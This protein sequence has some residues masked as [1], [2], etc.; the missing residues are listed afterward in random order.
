MKNLHFTNT[1]IQGGFWGHFTELNRNVT[2]HSVYDRF[3]ETGRFAALRCDWKPGQPNQ[4]H[5]FWDSDVAKWLES[6]A[7]LTHT[8]WDPALEALVDEA[9]ENICR[10]QKPSGYFNSYYLTVEPG[11]EFQVRDNHELYCAG[12]LMEAAIAYD[13]ATGKDALLR[14]MCRYADY[15]YQVFVV[16]QRAA[17]VTP[18]HE[19]IELALLK[20]ADYTGVEKYRQLAEFFLNQRGL[21][22]EP[23]GHPDMVILPEYDQSEFPIRELDEAKGHAVRAAYLYIA[24]AMLA[25]ER[26]DEQLAQVCQNLLTGIVEQKLSITGGVGS[27][28]HGENYGKPYALPNRTCYNETCAAI[29]LALF[30]K[31]MQA[32]Q[33]SSVYGDVIERILFNGFLSGLS[34]NGKAFFYENALEIDLRDYDLSL[35]SKPENNVQDL[36][37]GTLNPRRLERLEVFNCSCCP[38]NVT[39]ILASLP[40]FAY[41]VDEN[42]VYCHQFLSARTELTMGGKPAVLEQKTNYPA[43]GKLSFTWHGEPATLAVRIPDWCVEYTGETENG[44]ARFAVTD[45]QTVELELP[46]E[47]HF[48]EA[49]P[50]VRDLAGSCAVMRGPL[51]Y[52]LEG[53]DNGSLR[54]VE[55]VSGGAVT[56]EDAPEYHAPVLKLEALRRPKMR[57]LYQLRSLERETFTARLIPYFAF[58]NRG[59]S[60]MMVWL[61]VR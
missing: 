16:E 5:I 27:E 17:F 41:T 25:K 15:I 22:Y 7:Y 21:R 48:V 51:V 10:N 56:V 57:S 52:C 61:P 28:G 35:L 33:V 18:G 59:P 44:F 58:A 3:A 32:L 13:Q 20:L 45:G 49:N 43:D 14:A 34:L 39:R 26:K 12:H 23:C 9:V 38:P 1:T 55:L 36:P 54:G 30:A 42:T 53:A 60:D 31:E 8:R 19:E 47:V 11:V 4:P 24:M 37:Y 29:A 6:A 40:Q 2:I 46:M 50:L